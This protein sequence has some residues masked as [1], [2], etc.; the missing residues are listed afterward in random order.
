MDG[1]PA[2]WY[3]QQGRL[4]SATANAHAERSLERLFALPEPEPA[5]LDAT[6]RAL[7][8]VRDDLVTDTGW[9]HL[10][11][12]IGA[13]EVSPEERRAAR[14][15][16]TLT[17]AA[18]SFPFA[19]SPEHE[20]A[21]GAH[22]DDGWGVVDD[23]SIWRNEPRSIPRFTALPR[24][25]LL[26]PTSAT[27]STL[28]PTNPPAASAPAPVSARRIRGLPRRGGAGGGDVPTP[29]RE[30]GAYDAWL[31]QVQ[32]RPARRRAAVPDSDDESAL[33]SSEDDVTV[34]GVRAAHAGESPR[35]RTREETNAMMGAALRSKKGVA[36][37]YCGGSPSF[38]TTLPA[39]FAWAEEGTER[40]PATRGCGALVCARALLDGVPAK[41]FTDARDA[42]E[43]P[44]ASS[45]L[46]PVAE[47]VGDWAGA[48]QDDC[49]RVGKRG[50]GGCKGCLT[51]DLGCKRCGNHLGYRLLRPCVTC[52][53]SRPS[54]TSYASVVNSTHIQPLVLSAGGVTGGGVVDGLLF[55]YRLGGVTALP[56]LVGRTPRDQLEA[57]ERAR[58]RSGEGGE[59]GVDEDE[60]DDARERAGRANAPAFR[61]LVEKRPRE[62]ERMRWKAIPS[63]QRDF[64]DGLVGEPGDWID[65]TGE[66][67]WLDNGIAKH[68]R[69]RTA[70]GVWGDYAGAISRN[71]RAFNPDLLS[72][73]STT[74]PPSSSDSATFGLTSGATLSRAHAIRL[75][76]PLSG[77]RRAA[78]GEGASGETYDRFRADAAS[79]ERRVRRRLADTAGG[80]VVDRLERVGYGTGFEAEERQDEASIERR[81]TGG[82]RETVGR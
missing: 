69:K 3:D 40:A 65:P 82:M 11:D 30:D 55:H 19:A 73:A 9:I 28:S 72:S 39:G 59:D 56:R 29:G 1:P 5:P 10:P 27:T 12:P 71:S 4:R 67:W 54:Y 51:R 18:A 45:D 61:R 74:V 32:A 34:T 70:D 6:R 80:E 16:F 66:T 35:R 26:L 63:A 42:R 36:L 76:V 78:N 43:E 25:G 50:W 75:R 57:E 41:V 13:P 64:Q 38:E 49:E 37:L 7:D 31:A 2:L 44:A 52:S 17:R 60:G 79:F 14:D 47:R 24:G 46:P 53:I 8:A 33:G 62:G 48:G 81:Q 21:P 58:A 22:G 68:P 15:A 77:A 23:A 20:G